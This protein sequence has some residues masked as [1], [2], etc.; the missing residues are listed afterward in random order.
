MLGQHEILMISTS[1]ILSLSLSTLTTLKSF[2]VLNSSS[3]SKCSSWLSIIFFWVSLMLLIREP[4]VSSVTGFWN[5]EHIMIAEML[6]YMD[7]L[8]HRN[9]FTSYYNYENPNSKRYGIRLLLL[10]YFTNSMYFSLIFL[11]F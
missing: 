4:G 10:T 6:L 8:N 11:L 1:S 3:V 7:A 5:L 9:T 2:E